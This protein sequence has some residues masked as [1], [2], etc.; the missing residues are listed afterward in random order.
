METVLTIT[1]FLLLCLHLFQRWAPTSSL[2]VAR[3]PLI[4]EVWFSGFL[5]LTPICLPLLYSLYFFIYLFLKPSILT[6][7]G[8]F[9]WYL[10]HP[11]SLSSA[12]PLFFP[13]SQ[14]SLS[15]SLSDSDKL[16]AG[17][18]NPSCRIPHLNTHS[19]MPSH[20]SLFSL[21]FPPLF[22]IHPF[23][24]PVSFHPKVSEAHWGGTEGKDLP[25]ISCLYM[26]AHTL[27]SRW[28]VCAQK[29]YV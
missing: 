5:F 17:L 24:P 8:L 15:L 21:S 28:T 7:L 18:G 13:L 4:T 9:L 25:D 10:P 22:P 19:L 3:I 11:L 1:F 2:A 23:F 6:L 14:H 12:S 27:R 20:S 26:C 29:Q 16:P